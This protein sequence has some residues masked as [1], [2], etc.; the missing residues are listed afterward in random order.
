MHFW[1][2]RLKFPF[3]RNQKGKVFGI[4]SQLIKLSKPN[5]GHAQNKSS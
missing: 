2:T 3:G 1:E 4:L 5:D